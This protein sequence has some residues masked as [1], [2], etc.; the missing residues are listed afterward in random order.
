VKALPRVSTE[1]LI[2]FF[3]RVTIEPN[4]CWV[5]A[6]TNYKGY[7]MAFG[8]SA[9]RVTYTWFVGPIPEGLH[10]DHLCFRR[11]CVNPEHL[12]AVTVA[13]NT[14]RGNQW[15]RTGRCLKGHSITPENIYTWKTRG[16]TYRGCLKCRMVSRRRWVYRR[17]VVN[18]QYQL[19]L[20]A[21]AS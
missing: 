4:G 18:Q 13:E 10:I 3:E 17:H 15:V 1:R 11:D 7:G 16:V 6:G 5:I 9:H 12:E 8:T 19:N 14:R 2:G 20:K 21:V